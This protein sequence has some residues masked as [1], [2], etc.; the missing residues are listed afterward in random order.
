M[1]YKVILKKRFINKLQQTLFYIEDKWGKAVADQLLEKLDARIA[2]LTLQPFVGISS[3]KIEN[4]KSFLLTK[5]NRVY[6]RV[7]GKQIEIVNLYDT[8]INPRKNPY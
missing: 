5:H 1:A 3:E 6:Y 7:K 4:A 8:R 2:T